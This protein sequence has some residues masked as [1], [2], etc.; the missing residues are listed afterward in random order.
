MDFNALQIPANAAADPCR[1]HILGCVDG[2]CGDIAAVN[3]NMAG[4]TSC[5]AA[6]ARA[7][8]KTLCGDIPAV[9]GDRSHSIGF[10]ASR[11]PRIVI[12]ADAR[13]AAA[14]ADREGIGIGS[15]DGK[16]AALRDCDSGGTPAACQRV[17]A[18]QGQIQLCVVIQHDCPPGAAGKVQIRQGQVDFCAVNG[19]RVP[20]VGCTGQRFAVII[21]FVT[22]IDRDIIVHLKGT[23][24]RH[25]AVGL[26]QRL[27]QFQAGG[28]IHQLR[29]LLRQ[30]R[31]QAEDLLE[32]CLHVH[33]VVPC[34]LLRQGGDQRLDGADAADKPAGLAGAGLDIAARAVMAVL[35]VQRPRD[36]AA[37]RCTLVGAVVR[38]LLLLAGE[39]AVAVAALIMD[40]DAQRFFGIALVCVFVGTGLALGGGG[41]AAVLC[42]FRVMFTE[43]RAGLRR[44]RPGGAKAQ[45][46]GQS[47]EGTQNSA[48]HKN[49]SHVSHKVHPVRNIES[50]KKTTKKRP[51]WA[52]VRHDMQLS[53]KCSL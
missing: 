31:V 29:F 30:V 22:V 10:P 34:D 35:A 39:Q 50:R 41:I 8:A 23:S 7:A 9:D 28:D 5:R 20:A 53:I 18:A 3:D 47:G 40:M 48:F 12:R 37:V 6:D 33:P 2:F 52:S 24:Q 49:T 17:A 42:M 21:V 27:E 43:R 26:I 1:T 25:G 45:A 36:A 4:S 32:L 44:Q 46:Q 15:V 14:A 13:A 16:R 38:L 51:Q 11:R 19:Q